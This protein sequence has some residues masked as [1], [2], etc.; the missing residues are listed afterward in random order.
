MSLND[1]DELAWVKLANGDEDVI[2]VTRNG[3]SILLR[4]GAGKVDGRQAAGVRGIRLGAGDE[5]VHMDLIRPESSLLIITERG[6]GKRTLLS[7][8]RKQ[9]RGG[10]GTMTAKITKKTGPIVAARAS[11]V[12]TKS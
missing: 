10:R 6:Y 7:R 8:Y 9:L 4:A 3:Q 11:T 12:P 2:L 1:D 5:V